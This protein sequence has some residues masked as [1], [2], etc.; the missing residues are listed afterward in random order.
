ME[1]E[2]N[3]W[4]VIEEETVA[5]AHKTATKK[6]RAARRR[7]ASMWFLGVVKWILLIVLV[8]GF[9]YTVLIHPVNKL[10]LRILLGDSYT[11][12]LK[13]FNYNTFAWQ[14]VGQIKVDGNLIY[15]SYNGNRI[16]YEVDGETIYEYKMIDGGWEKEKI[17]EQIIAFG[18]SEEDAVDL[19]VLLDRRNYRWAKEK[20]FVCR[21]KDGVDI[22][23]FDKV[24]FYRVGG[25]YEMKLYIDGNSA[26]IVFEDIGK[27]Q[28]NPP[29]K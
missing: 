4:E 22:G 5:N 19:S 11:M 26:T 28:I 12:N 29:W 1:N 18:D 13:A 15:I 6:R 9:V 24:E 25:K 16:Y 7:T 10:K 3:P 21:I 8:L 27:T 23:Q 17:D 20:L 2:R 14:S